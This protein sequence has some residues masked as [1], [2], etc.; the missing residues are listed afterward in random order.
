MYFAKV[1]IFAIHQ[2]RNSVKLASYEKE[3]DGAA[4][5]I[6]RFVSSFFNSFNLASNRYL[7]AET[8]F[9]IVLSCDRKFIG[10]SVHFFSLTE[11]TTEE[12]P[13]AEATELFW[14][15]LAGNLVL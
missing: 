7:F 14:P 11:R 4:T 2:M 8:I 12:G 6:G 9:F 10:S 15:H 5:L 13:L 3:D 1:T